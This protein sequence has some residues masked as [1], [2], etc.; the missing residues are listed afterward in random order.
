MLSVEPAAEKLCLA[1]SFTLAIAALAC[2][3]SAPSLARPPSPDTA[4]ADRIEVF[5]AERRL[6]L[7]RDGQA[8]KTYRVAL[9]ADPVGP[10]RQ[11]GDHRTPEGRYTIDFHKPD[12][13][14]HLALH[15][16][17]PNEEDRRR[18]ARRG[19]SPGGS[20][21]IHGLPNGL[22]GF[23]RVHASRDWTD[24]CIAVTDGEIDEIA[25]AVPDGTVIVIYP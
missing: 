16:S 4:L 10:K 13:T 12:S 14:F 21:M 7:L 17:Y 23:G 2:L 5:K 19:I 1:R 8:L 9:G 24:G 22:A 6:V 15:I 25:R 18:A 3:G 20:I 11:E